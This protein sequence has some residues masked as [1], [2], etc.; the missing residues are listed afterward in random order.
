MGGCRAGSVSRSRCLVMESARVR[1][2]KVMQAEVRIG[3][4]DSLEGRDPLTPRGFNTT[5]I[6]RTTGNLFREHCSHNW[7]RHGSC[8]SRQDLLESARPARAV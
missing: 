1:R 8:W 4:V 6:A 3:H 2:A 5:L 7:I